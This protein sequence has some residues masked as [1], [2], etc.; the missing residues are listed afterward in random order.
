MKLVINELSFRDATD[1]VEGVAELA[2]ELDSSDAKLIDRQID[3]DASMDEVERIDQLILSMMRDSLKPHDI[4]IAD[5][6]RIFD[7]CEGCWSIPATGSSGYD[8][9]V[10]VIATD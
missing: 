6:T 8:G 9:F 5:D 3:G 10:V 4:I 7:S 2:V 1:E